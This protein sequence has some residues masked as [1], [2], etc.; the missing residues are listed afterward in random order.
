MTLKTRNIKFVDVWDWDNLVVNTYGRP[1]K[2]QQQNGCIARQVIEITV[3]S[4]GFD[5]E[6]DTVPEIVNGN[7][8]GVSFKS[9]LERSPS[10][11]LEGDIN[12]CQDMCKF[13]LDLWWTRNFYPDLQTVANDLHA[14]GLLEAGHYA[15]NVD[16]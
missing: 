12:K 9:W 3:P 11:I 5:F 6:N 16:W 15:I 14:K 8:M 7:D 13:H 10:Q 2:L 1:Y 4:N